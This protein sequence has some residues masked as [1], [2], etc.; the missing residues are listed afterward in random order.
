VSWV[1]VAF[2]EATE[3]LIT[4][5][6]ASLKQLSEVGRGFRIDWEYGIRIFG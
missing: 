5:R 1:S 3:R 2:W 4:G 6:A